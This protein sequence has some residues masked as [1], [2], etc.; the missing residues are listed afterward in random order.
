MPLLELSSADAV[1]R[2]LRDHANALITFSAHWCG[3]CK[4]SKPALEQLAIKYGDANKSGVQFGIAYEDALQDAIH[5]Y[6]V[7]AFPTYVLFASGTEVKRIEGANLA[8]VEEMVQSVKVGPSIPLVGGET[9]GG[10]AA[11]LSLADAREARLAK[12]AGT[13]NSTAAAVAAVNDVATVETAATTASPADAMEVDKPTEASASTTTEMDIDAVAPDATEE[14]EDPPKEDPTAK[15]NPEW[16]QT[17]TEG[18]GFSLLRAQKGLL[19]GNGGT[20]E[21]AVEW[22]AE[23]QDDVDIDQENIALVKATSYKC[24]DCGKILSS[25][26]NLELHANKTGHSDFEES[27]QRVEP[28]TEEQKAAKIAEIKVSVYVCACACACACIDQRRG[29]IPDSHTWRHHI[30]FWATST[31]TCSNF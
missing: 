11:P 4:V 24:N 6:N 31:A 21:G 15:L 12:L 13:S 22:L 19:Y 3:P 16:L 2:F 27:L 5:H 20:V 29:E 26:A 18:M 17:L 1:Q 7:R 23:H 8:S 14:E 30:F 9:L 10:S 28:L 25:M